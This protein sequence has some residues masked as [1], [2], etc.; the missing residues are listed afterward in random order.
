MLKRLQEHLPEADVVLWASN[1]DRGVGKMLAH[2]FP[3]VTLYE[4]ATDDA[5]LPLNPE[6]LREW[7]KAD[8]FLHG[9]GPSLVAHDAVRG[10]ADHADGRPWG[11]YGITLENLSRP[12]CD[13]LSSAKF[14]YCRDTASLAHVRKL[15]VPGPKL[16]FAPDATFASRDRDELTAMRYLRS[17]GLE[18]G[19]FLVVIPRL[20]YTPYFQIHGRPPTDHEARRYEISMAHKESDHAKLREVVTRWVRETGRSVLVCS[21]MTYQIDLAKEVIKE[22]LPTDVLEKT[23]WRESYW[24]PDEAASVYARAA[25]MVSYEMHSPI[26]AFGVGTPA[27]YV[28]Q[29]TDTCKGQMWRDVGLGDWMF[30]IDACSGDEIAERALDIDRDPDAATALLG[31]ACGTVVAAQGKAMQEIRKLLQFRGSETRL[32]STA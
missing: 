17:V 31:T 15:E 18:A 23:V 21:E 13:L 22:H 32:V 3:G 14:I 24:R 2:H 9:S 26:L 30:E 10:W 16:G 12:D 4:S 5:G 27:I 29:P 7:K 8:L 11:A 28:R 6:L 25:V 1:L 19:G 20:R